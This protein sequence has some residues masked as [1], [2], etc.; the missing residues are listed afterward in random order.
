MK[1][2]LLKQIGNVIVLYNELEDI[3]LNVECFMNKIPFLSGEEFGQ[4]V[5]IPSILLSGTPT[6]YL[7]DINEDGE[8]C[9][10]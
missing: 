2:A 7:E 9:G 1:I 10:N 5:L 4:P 3:L 6:H 8:L